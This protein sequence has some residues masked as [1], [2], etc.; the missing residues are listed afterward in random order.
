MAIHWQVKFKSLRTDTLYIV[1][2]YDDDYTGTPV[3]L[4]G[5]AQP[6]V[7]QESNDDDIFSP[8]RTQ[9]GY[10]RIVVSSL[11][12]IQGIIPVSAMQRPV[13]MVNDDS[14]VVVWTGYIQDSVFNSPWDS[15]CLQV[16]MP[17]F[18]PLEVMKA[19]PFEADVKYTSLNQILCNLFSVFDH[20][21]RVFIPNDNTDYMS[22]LFNTVLFLGDGEKQTTTY[23]GISD[24]SQ[25][26]GDKAYC[27]NVIE[28]LCSY[29]GWTARDNGDA[30]WFVSIGASGYKQYLISRNG[31][32]TTLTQAQS[33]SVDSFGVT[34]GSNR[35]TY[36]YLPGASYIDITEEVTTDYKMVRTS[37]A[38]GRTFGALGSQWDFMYVNYQSGSGSATYKQYLISDGSEL[39][40]FVDLFAR[41]YNDPMYYGGQMMFFL[42][43]KYLERL[44]GNEEKFSFKPVLGIKYGGGKEVGR[45]KSVRSLCGASFPG[46]I[47]LMGK[48]S[49]YDGV[50]SFKPDENGQ[51][52]FALKWGNKYFNNTTRSWG[53]TLTVNVSDTGSVIHG[54]RIDWGSW[55]QVS[56]SDLYFIPTTASL[57]GEIELIIYGNGANS[58]YVGFELVEDLSMAAFVPYDGIVDINTDN[59]ENHFRKQLDYAKENVYERT[60]IFATHFA[61]GQYGESLVLNADRTFYSGHESNLLS[62]LAA[63]K[64]HTS[65][66]IT[67]DTLM[68]T[69]NIDA[70]PCDM[71]SVGGE[72]YAI[73]SQ[74][75]SW[76][77]NVR[78]FVIQKE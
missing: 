24:G 74:R 42:N 47:A 41:P 66:Q 75:T 57:D 19:V 73:V 36:N 29:F 14:N 2:V 61:N 6:F 56:P 30:L 9:T 49:R 35:N 64:G 27:Y 10:L 39:P 62:V 67:I 5:A 77:D 53:D 54:G 8:M 78:T 51:L 69:G 18:S 34:I 63:W 52:P 46:G 15:G 38:D 13:E 3:Q 26:P 32:T 59:S 65:E 16:E 31:G 55:L 40:S 60:S 76:R 11:A 7:T 4:T 50:D 72:D 28:E 44:T 23:P 37:L 17:V 1:N 43:E 71:V 68:N 70:R 21:A 33:Y 25:P 22:L 20:Y 45:F 58:S 48:L 12:D